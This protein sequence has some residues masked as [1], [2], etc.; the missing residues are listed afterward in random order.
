MKQRDSK[1]VEPE[2]LR[3][4]WQWLATV[5][6]VLV[7]SGVLG[8]LV[9]HRLHAHAPAGPTMGSVAVNGID[10]SCHLPIIAGS[11]GAFISLP[12]GAVTIDHSIALDL[13]KGGYGYTYDALV[14]R[15]VPVPGSALSPDG[16]SY[17]YIAQTTGVPGEMTTISVRTHDIVAGKDRV[18]WEGSGSFMGPDQVTWLPSGIYFSAV[19]V[20]YSGTNG[21]AFPSVY[22]S[23]P[24]HPG[25]PQRVGP[26]PAAQPP[27]PGQYD[28]SGPD[29]FTFFGGGAAWATGNRISKATPSPD[30]PP[31]PGAFG[32]D[33]VLRMD[34]R[35][36]SVST[37][38]S[39][40]GTELVSVIGLDEHG[41]PILALFQPKAPVES[42][43][44]PSP[45]E[46]PAARLLLLTG[47]NQTVTLTS[48]NTDFHLGSIPWADSH[49]IWFGDWNALWLYT[50][51][52]GL[53]RVA[54]I[55]S[56]LF[57]TPTP[58]PAYLPKS[59]FASG[60]RPGM[61][62]YMQGTLVTPAGSCT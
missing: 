39:V 2:E 51:H 42:G 8:G 61:P 45:Y 54:T 55:P 59:P 52:G 7:T 31:A 24:N 26:N 57:P 48:G 18:V 25:A 17:A 30:K 47:P 37:W 20:P 14:R 21:A 3:G 56:G 27:L 62:S 34:L 33:R 5:I 10:F 35:D 43:P 46:P 16:R 19:L 6:A 12:D 38:Y 15:W 40:S 50:E 41:R 36:G 32:P 1:P 28:Y 13:Y 53:H 11:A 44:I 22:V 49:G 60:A 58:P 9:Y 23:D 29:L 4:P